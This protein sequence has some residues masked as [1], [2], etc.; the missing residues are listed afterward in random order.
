MT[1][2]IATAV[3]PS[4]PWAP[5]AGIAE[6]YGRPPLAAG[7]DPD[8]YVTWL[9]RVALTIRPADPFE[10]VLIKDYVDIAW[11]I[12]RLRRGKA[13]MLDRA[14]ASNLEAFV[15][16]TGGYHLEKQLKENRANAPAVLAQME[17]TEQTFAA[18]AMC[19]I[20]DDLEQADRIIAAAEERRNAA[21]KQIA[22]HREDLA[23]RL[24]KS[25]AD[26]VDAEFEDIRSVE[27]G[28]PSHGREMAAVRLSTT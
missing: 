11:E 14:R 9:R 25:S 18:A 8:A 2:D 26:I 19:Y 17:M 10:W 12:V 15:R 4:A 22:Q 7:E 20:L 13:A 3:I 16:N 23:V 24:R 5:P 28:A 6:L 21:L 27:V 1:A